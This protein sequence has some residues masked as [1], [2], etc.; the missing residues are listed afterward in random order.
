MS[1]TNRPENSRRAKVAIF[2]FHVKLCDNSISK[3]RKPFA[4]GELSS[5]VLMRVL[6]LPWSFFLLESDLENGL[7]IYF[8]ND[9]MLL[10]EDIVDIVKIFYNSVHLP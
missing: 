5:V 8:F 2:I 7:F 10:S 6:D 3:Y 1:R 9:P 4:R